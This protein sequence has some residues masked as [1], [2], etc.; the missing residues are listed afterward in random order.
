MR[1]SLISKNLRKKSKK[2]VI[3]SKLDGTVAKVGDPATTASDGSNFMT[4][5]SKEGF[6]VKG[7]VSE[8]M[9]DQIKEGTILNCSGQNGDFEAEVLMFRNIRFPETIIPEMGIQMFLI[10]PIQ[11]LFRINQ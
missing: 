9:L 7:T 3:Y 5:K 10:I 1:V 2:K 11:Q 4:I 6:Y 8:L